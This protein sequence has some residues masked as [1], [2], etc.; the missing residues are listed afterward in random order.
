[1]RTF[2]K[3]MY[4]RTGL[5]V[6]YSLCEWVVSATSTPSTLNAHFVNMQSVLPSSPA[7]VPLT[8]SL[9]LDTKDKVAFYCVLGYAHDRLYDAADRSGT[10]S[11]LQYCNR[12]V[13]T[14]N[15]ILYSSSSLPAAIIQDCPQPRGTKVDE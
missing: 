7:H 15:Y 10:S 5:P 9:Y 8:A 3:G 12:P 14:L 4:V 11:R 1:M 6:S 2:V 13:R